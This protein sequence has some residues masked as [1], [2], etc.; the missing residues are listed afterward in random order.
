MTLLALTASLASAPPLANP[1][2]DLG[3]KSSGGSKFADIVDALTGEDSQSNAGA[4]TTPA[5][6]SAQ[7]QASSR[8]ATSKSSPSVSIDAGLAGL[9]YGALG[10]PASGGA[11][12]RASGGR[13]SV[14]TSD[15][16]SDDS[17]AAKTSAAAGEALRRALTGRGAEASSDDLSADD[18]TAAAATSTASNGTDANSALAGL[19][20]GALALP[21]AT[22]LD[23]SVANSG[24][25]ES[26]ARQGASTSNAAAANDGSTTSAGALWRALGARGAVAGSNQASGGLAAGA[27]ATAAQDDAEANFALAGALDAPPTLRTAANGDASLGLSAAQSRTYLGVDSAEQSEAKNSILRSQARPAVNAAAAAGSDATGTV[28]V[29]VAAAASTQ[30]QTQSDKRSSSGHSGSPSASA[31]NPSVDVGSTATV[32]EAAPS[33]FDA[34]INSAV[35][36]SGPIAVSQLADWLAGEASGLSSQTASSGATSAAAVGGGQAVKELQINL[37]PSDLGAVSVKMRMA[38]GQLSVV[39]EVA[40]PSTLNSIENERDA[41]TDRLGLS[42]QPLAALIIRPAATTQTSAE[43]GSAQDQQSG[44]QGNAQ[45]DPNQSSRGNEQQTSRGQDGAGRWSRQTAAQPSPA[46]RG[47]GDLVV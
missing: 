19:L 24:G 13:G 12:S 29:V 9:V 18:S 27:S 23:A 34:G 7:D 37:E 39:M 6:A 8:E 46:G 1:A 31:A 21:A 4:A 10:S 43:S 22:A 38:N 3:G 11:A 26:A 25:E 44:N 5:A 16:T 36:G 47:F 15:R 30:S 14:A 17:V 40:K 35:A 33:L 28:D 2:H 41:I 32:A 20:Y 45:G 42:A